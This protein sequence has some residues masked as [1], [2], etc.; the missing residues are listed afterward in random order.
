MFKTILIANR[1]EI[2]CRIIK[3]ARKLGINVV[4]IYS[5]ID[6]NSKHVAMSDK[7]YY[8][9]GNRSSESYL[10]MEKIIN[11]ALKSNA[12]AIHPGYGF[13]SENCNFVKMCN[14]AN[15]KFIGPPESAINAMG[16]K[17]ESK[18]IMEKANVPIVPGY[19][20]DN[21]DKEYLIEKA[22]NIKYPIMIK[23]DLGGGGKGM[24]IVNHENEFIEALASAQNEASKSFKSSKVL[25][26]RY[27]ANS[28]HIE[29]QVF[30]DN[31]GNYVHL[32]ERDCTIQRRH[33]KVVEE[34]PSY[35]DSYLRNDLCSKAILAAKAV[36]YTN[37]GTVEFIYDID[38][39]EFYFMEMNTRL[40]VEHPI[41]EMITRQDFVEWQ[42]RIAS[43][44]KLPLTQDQ[45]KIHG[46][47]IECRIYS[48]DPNNNFLP[49]SGKIYYLHEPG[50]ID[51]KTNYDK[52][53][54]VETGIRQGDDVSIFYDPMISKLVCFAENR[55]LA[56]QKTVKALEN[57]KIEGLPTN[58]NFINKILKHPKYLEWDFDTNFINK[59]KDSLIENLDKQSENTYSNE[60][61]L[62]A[63]LIKQL[64]SRNNYNVDTNSGPWNS[65]GFRVNYNM[66]SKYK[67]NLTNTL[68]NENK[69]KSDN[70]LECELEYISANCFNLKINNTLV[71]EN[72]K[73]NLKSKNNLTITIPNEKISNTHFYISNNNNKI[74][75]LLNKETI[76]INFKEDDY[77]IIEDVFFGDKSIVKAPMSSTVSKV[78]VN[79]GDRV[80]KGQSLV[81]IEAMKM[82]HIMKAAKSG[83]I[84]AVKCKV[85][86]FI[87]EGKVLIEF[88][89]EENKN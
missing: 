12:Q 57:Y 7:A 88:E 36:K 1:G 43:G 50:N 52:D 37:A 51:S 44:E 71:Y 78:F 60:N 87:E 80:E 86:E 40:Q 16:S 74:T 10:N 54:R 66:N 49:G 81:A 4:S 27:I 17:I 89:N 15:I 76:N 8:L 85:D 20:G 35:L 84:K 68:T 42:I 31:F 70:Y 28:K 41:S 46:H 45:L 9:G 38:T 77:G 5:D 55:N 19:Y 64:F 21:Q 3:T 11:I 30:G 13:L 65:D 22:R 73:A 58:V 75:L 25:L 14:D 18:K 62:K 53:V 39:Q 34:A 79:N 82:E 63:V 32:Y 2:A 72:V 67:I 56:I 69:E 33:Q 6:T 59:Y 83:I 48:E 24:R 23:A 61:L 29:V 47:A 26:E